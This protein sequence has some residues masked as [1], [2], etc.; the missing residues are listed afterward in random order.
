L[1]PVRIYI[2]ESSLVQHEQLSPDQQF[3]LYIGD[4][5][6]CVTLALLKQCQEMGNRPHLLYLKSSG[7]IVLLVNS[8]V[9]RE[10]P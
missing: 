7:N 2:T 9:G 1:H 4:E 10:R 6:D 5:S 3:R 8:V